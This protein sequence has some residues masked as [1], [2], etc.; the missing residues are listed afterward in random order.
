[1]SYNRFSKLRTHI[2]FTDA[3]EPNETDKFWKVRILYDKIRYRCMQLSLETKLCI[4]EQIIPFKGQLNVKQYIKGKPCPWGIKLY[5]LYGSSGLLYDFVLYQGPTTELNS[6]HQEVFGQS[7]G[8]VIKLTE[9]ITNPNH[10][11]YFDNY[12][13]DYQLLQWLQN[14]HIYASCTARTDRSAKP[15]L[16]PDTLIAKKERGF[17][18]E[19]LKGKK[20]FARDEAKKK[21]SILWCLDQKL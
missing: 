12:F 10:Q 14:R 16:L 2:H 7:V 19:I 21:K 8:L 15:P 1:M 20:I 17:S 18:Q 6:L 3:N 9:R 4:D 11:L 5:A 13:S